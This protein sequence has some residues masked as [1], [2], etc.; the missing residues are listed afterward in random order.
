[1]VSFRSS[2]TEQKSVV[3]PPGKVKE[4]I[5]PIE[6]PR[7]QHS[8]SRRHVSHKRH[9]HFSVGS[10]DDDDDND[11]D[12]D[13]VQVETILYQLA[14][15][16]CKS[17]VVWTK[18]EI[19]EFQ[20]ECCD[21]ADFHKT[22]EDY[23]ACIYHLF[24]CQTR[25]APVI[26]GGNNDDDDDDNVP[27]N[28]SV[29]QDTAAI[30]MLSKSPARGLEARVAPILRVHRQWGVTTILATQAKLDKGKVTD[31]EKREKMLRARSLQISKRSRVFALKLAQGD[32]SE[33]LMAG[34]RLSAVQ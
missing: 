32:A 17:H 5:Q 11:D 18:H 23:V 33:A 6:L 16:K 20:Q 31:R 30:R 10:G 27:Q 24:A 2:I 15:A 13:S 7:H 9:V 3:E 25:S 22:N 28:P 14:P 19:K 4:P 8:G 21:M 34:R 26:S 1:M 12:N 29:R